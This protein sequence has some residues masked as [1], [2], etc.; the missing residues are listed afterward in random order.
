[1]DLIVKCFESRVLF[2]LFPDPLQPTSPSHRPPFFL[3]E[4]RQ[5]LGEFSFFLVLGLEVNPEIPLSSA[6][7][8]ICF[9]LLCPS[10]SSSC[11]W[12]AS[13]FSVCREFLHFSPRRLPS[14]PGPVL[15]AGVS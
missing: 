9:A 2:F 15:L 3:P 14:Q 11:W 12:S 10:A 13:R 8:R 7:F 6:N 5:K 4:H 1:M